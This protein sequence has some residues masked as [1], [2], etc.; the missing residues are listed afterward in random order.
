MMELSNTDPVENQKIQTNEIV[1]AGR[2]SAP[3]VLRMLRCGFRVL[4]RTAPGLGGRW[5]YWLW[6][7]THR[8]PEPQREQHYR[9]VATRVP[10]KY[11]GKP[12]AVY[13][14]GEGPV[15][16]LTHG[17]N[18]RAT[19]LWKFIDPLVESGF[20]V[21]ALD[22]PAHGQSAGKSTDLFK[23]AE[24]I[25]LVAKAFEPLHGIIAHSLGN[26]AIVMALGNGLD[27]KK[28]I[29]ISPP[30]QSIV[31]LTNYAEALELSPVIQARMCNLFEK[32]Y[33]TEVWKQTSI[34]ENVNGLSIPV[35][36]IHDK[37]DR[38]VAW[39][40][41]ESI[42]QNWPGAEFLTTEALGHRRILRN[43]GVIEKSI[44]FLSS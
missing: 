22:M 30:A 33:G 36:I 5:A 6:F 42:A 23:M 32:N 19:Q 1:P 40:E 29:C 8:F 11:A 12:L 27:A 10:F 37:D 15:V 31:M 20:R 41:G 35:L 44:A 17:W 21:V 34:A 26:S 24:A 16:L 2:N 13:S 18:G 14:W 7:R 38:E 4:D 43:R 39:A 28:A 25:H 3:Y 9:R